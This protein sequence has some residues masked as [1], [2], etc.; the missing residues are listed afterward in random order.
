MI[1]KIDNFVMEGWVPTEVEQALVDGNSKEMANK[2]DLKEPIPDDFLEVQ[3][4][5][6]AISDIKQ[7]I[8]LWTS[9]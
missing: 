1:K 8:N 6:Q 3:D 2:K 7:E 9:E 5:N 4:F